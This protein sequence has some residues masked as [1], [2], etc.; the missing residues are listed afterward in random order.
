VGAVW[1]FPKQSTLYSIPSIYAY[2][3]P[4]YISI[5]GRIF[6]SPGAR[7]PFP[8]LKIVPKLANITSNFPPV[9]WLL[10]P[11]DAGFFKDSLCQPLRHCAWTK[12]S[13]LPAPAPCLDPSRVLT[14][15][16]PLFDIEWTPGILLRHLFSPQLTFLSESPLA[17]DRDFLPLKT[18]L[19]R[20]MYIFDFS[21]F[22]HLPL[23][24]PHGYSQFPVKLDI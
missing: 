23:W 13:C 2:C 21:P 19:F 12:F 6:Y 10:I 9:L 4:F 1:F 24:I 17:F 22:P 14:V 8:D 7:V 5:P 16:G 18:S 20:S 15:S 3:I 11:P